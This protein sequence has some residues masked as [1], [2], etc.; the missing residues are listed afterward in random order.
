[1]YRVS[2]AESLES[3]PG[4]RQAQHGMAVGNSLQCK[5]GLCLVHCFIPRTLDSTQNILDTHIFV[6]LMSWVYF[7]VDRAM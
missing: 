7:A 4:S 1:M 3:G 6:T 5:Q 2:N